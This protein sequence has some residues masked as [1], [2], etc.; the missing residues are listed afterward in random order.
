MII[1]VLWNASARL[2]DR[3]RGDLTMADV[4]GEGDE[5]FAGS[6]ANG[7]GADPAPL[8]ANALA[9]PAAES[10]GRLV[11]HPHPSKLDHCGAQTRITGLRDT[12]FV[13]DAATLPRTGSQAGIGR[14]LPS[15]LKLAEQT[16][17]VEHGSEFRA[18][19]LEPHKECG[20]RA[21]LCQ[22]Q[23]FIAFSFDLADLA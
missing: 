17:K 13:V 11:S 12:L 22:L 9:E 18:N 5:E 1:S 10:T 20:G 3:T 15:V 21:R 14:Q 2:H 19:A 7:K 16:L 8:G 4:S 6:R 23:H